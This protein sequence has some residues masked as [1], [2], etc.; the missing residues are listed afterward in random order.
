MADKARAK[1]Q[2]TVVSQERQLLSEVVD[3]VTLPASE[4]EITVLPGHVPLF[5]PLQTGVVTYRDHDNDTNL[6]V[7]KGFVDVGVNNEITIIVDTATRARDIS[8]DQAEA[9]IKAAHET[10]E[11]SRDQQELLMAEASL[12]LA[13]LEAKVARSTKRTGI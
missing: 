5:S 6:V 13:L 11:N 2:L 7:S 9:A 4:G 10:M 12:R 3:S 1:L 8:L